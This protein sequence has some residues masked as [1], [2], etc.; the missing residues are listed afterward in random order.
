M[1]T[2]AVSALVL[3]AGEGTRMRSSLPK[4]L[5]PLCGRPMVFHV[6]DALRDL[7]VDR[8]IVVVGHGA[9]TVT[10]VIQERATPARPVEFVDQRVQRGTGDAA[11]VGLT[12]LPELVDDLDD[13]DVV[14]LPGDT[15]LLR[16]ETLSRLVRTHRASEAAATV[17]TA[18]VPDPS[19]YGRVVR[20]K[21]GNIARV[22]EDTDLSDRERRIDE[23]STSIYCFRRGILA[24]ALRRLSPDNAQGQYYLT[25]VVAVLH[26]AG[27]RVVSVVAADPTE[28]RGV[29]DR[30]QLATAEAE[31][32]RRINHEWMRRGVTMVDPER[33]YLDVTV[34]LSEE[35]T[36][37]PGVQLSGSSTVGAGASLG[38]DTRLVDCAV[39]AD[40]VVRNASGQQAEVGAG[41][42]V[43]PYAVLEPGCRVAPGAVTGP[44][45]VGQADDEADEDPSGQQGGG[46]WPCI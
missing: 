12:G 15:P 45:F 9:E 23:I 20:D 7:P 27:Y 36:L 37:L 40:A 26:D 33:T 30:A 35:V 22:V 31:L 18:R 28:V 41:A 5:H 32:R 24:P 34:E 17:L 39:G 10:K 43:G 6:I 14:I 11:A 25:D 38:P 19:G 8:V 2:R 21:D 44:F 1:A 3:A 29:N 13:A 42:R 46:A 4:P 16:P